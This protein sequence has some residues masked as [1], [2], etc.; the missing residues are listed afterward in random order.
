MPSRDLF[1]PGWLVTGSYRDTPLGVLKSG[2]ESE[3]HLVAR[4]GAERTTLLAQKRFK[5]RDRRSFQDNWMYRGV[6]GEGTRR[7]H[8]A[9]KKNTR[10]GHEAAHARWIAHEWESL[11]VLH[12]AGATVPPPVELLDDGYLMA[13]V[14]DGERAA[15]RL[16]EIDLGPTDARRVWDELIDEVALLVSADRV[17]GDLSAF[18]VLWWRERAVLID[19]SQTVDVVTHPAAYDLLTRDITTLA[20]YFTRRGVD[21]D[22]RR[23]LDRVGADARRFTR[24]LAR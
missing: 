4:T 16:A 23:T 22:V 1:P 7:E 11:V 3:V 19:F 2:K 9:M 5:A 18:N 24:Q 13:F 14:G 10:F 6:W 15:P 20:R 12:D 21:V 8:R 17:H